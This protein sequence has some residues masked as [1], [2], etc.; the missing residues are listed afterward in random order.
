MP[1]WLTLEAA[2]FW[3]ALAG[4]LVTAVLGVLPDD[5]QWL[6]VLSAVLTALAVYAVPNRE[7]TDD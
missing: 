1:T 3:V 5:P 6:V 4:G 7:S 2:K